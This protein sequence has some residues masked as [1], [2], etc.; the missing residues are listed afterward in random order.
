MVRRRVVAALEHATGG[1]VEMGKF[2]VVP[3]HFQVEVQDLTIHGTEAPGELPYAHV[4]RLI[5]RAKLRSALGGELGFSSLVVERPVVHIVV[6]PDGSTNQ[7][8]PRSGG[9]SAHQTVEK[10]FSFS[11]GRLEVRRGEFILNDAKTP[12][13]FTANDIS[14]DLT[15]SLL[16]QRYSGDL[17]L[18]KIGTKFDNYRPIAWMAEAHFTVGKDGIEVRSLKATSGRSRLQASGRLT[19]FSQPSVTLKYDFTADLAEGAAVARY[20]E[21]RQGTVQ[22]SGE[23][24]WSAANFS[25]HGKLQVQNLDWRDTSTGLRVATLSSD[26]TVD[27]QRLA[28]SHLQARLLGGEVSGEAEVT[29]WRSQNVKASKANSSQQEKGNVKLSLKGISAAE[30]AAA[31]S[32]TARPLARMNLA[33]SAQGNVE[34][35]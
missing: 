35:K 32:S 31:L 5:A 8:L 34:V 22:A 11:I 17:L 9:A 6:Y 16:H 1:R 12:L 20:S 21:L 23:G 2:N 19:N 30:V 33:G 25:S 29:D 28:L 13:D 18:G 10:I 26:Y 3:L 14:A 4:D 7:P 24:T 15:Y 27:S